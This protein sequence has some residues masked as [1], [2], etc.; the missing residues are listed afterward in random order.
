MKDAAVLT[1]LRG[2]GVALG[3]YWAAVAAAGKLRPVLAAAPVVAE[4][5]GGLKA[6]QEAGGGDNVHDS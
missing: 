4:L 6:V 2:D 5:H 1:A 3:P